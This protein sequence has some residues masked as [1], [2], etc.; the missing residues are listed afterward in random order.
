IANNT[1]G[2]SDTSKRADVISGAQE[3]PPTSSPTPEPMQ[4]RIPSAGGVNLYDG[5]VYLQATDLRIPGRGL[6]WQ[7]HRTYRSSIQLHSALGENWDFTDNRHLLEVNSQ[8]L[9]E[10]HQ[11]F[12]APKTGD[13]V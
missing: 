4:N 2:I 11:S 12:P 13:L 8:N 3:G 6:D 7:F 10:V 9:T 5:E 1:L